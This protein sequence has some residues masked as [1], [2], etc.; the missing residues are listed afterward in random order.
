[1]IVRAPV[2]LFE[3]FFRRERNSI[4]FGGGHQEKAPAAMP[5]GLLL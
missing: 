4:P 2:F 5:Q 3:D 1:M